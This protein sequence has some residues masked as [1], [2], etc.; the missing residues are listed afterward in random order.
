[1][2]GMENPESVLIKTFGATPLVKVLDFLLTY[3]GFDYSKSQIAK[4]TGVARMTME[5]I[6]ERLIESGMI[7]KT[8][9]IGQAEMYKLNKL[10]SELHLER[11]RHY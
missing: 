1:M 2:M 7:T 4:E 11:V 6:W 10:P 9:K 8:R 3:E 5:P